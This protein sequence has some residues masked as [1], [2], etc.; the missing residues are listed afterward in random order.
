MHQVATVGAVSWPTVLLR[1]C[2]PRERWVP[3]QVTCFTSSG[4]CSLL[5]NS[6]FFGRAPG[7]HKR[8]VILRGFAPWLVGRW[9]IKPLARVSAHCA[10]TVAQRKL[11][12]ILL[13]SFRPLQ[14]WG[15]CSC[16]RLGHIRLRSA[17]TVLWTNEACVRSMFA[18]LG[19]GYR[20]SPLS[21][22]AANELTSTTRFL[23]LH[24]HGR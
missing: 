11:I 24:A 21:P 4:L 16:H 7:R 17:R 9:H 13:C 22:P 18:L 19:D 15:I 1:T 2:R 23:N 8:N 3:S 10:S 5:L 12:D 6:R 14:S 20:C